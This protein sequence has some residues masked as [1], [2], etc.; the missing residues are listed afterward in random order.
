MDWL[1]MVPCNVRLFPFRT[2][3]SWERLQIH[4]SPDQDNAV[5]KDEC[6][7]EGFSNSSSSPPELLFK[8]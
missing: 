1:L 6:I 3:R 8:K 2:Q 4:R 5:T 7:L